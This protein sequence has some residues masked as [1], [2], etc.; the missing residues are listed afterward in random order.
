MI[1]A[2]PRLGSS[3]ALLLL[4]ASFCPA[5]AD[6][7]C[8][9][10]GGHQRLGLSRVVTIE[11]GGGY[12]VGL[13]TTLPHR[14]GLLQPNE[15]ALT[16]DDGPIPWITRS[17]LATLQQHCTKATFFSVGQ[18]AIA[19]PQVVREELDQGHSVG[20]HTWSHPLNLKRLKS[21]AATSEMERGFAGVSA[22]AGRPISA[23]FRFPGLSDS[24]SMVAYL[25]G[26]GVAAVSVDVVSN[27]SYI[28]DA[29]KLIRETL[30]KIEAN[31]GGII[32]FHD[33][34]ATTAKALPVILDTLAQRGYH[35]VQIVSKDALRPDP[36]LV[37]P[38]APKVEQAL[39]LAQS[40]KQPMVPFYGAV[41]PRPAGEVFA[42]TKDG[43]GPVRRKHAGANK[44]GLGRSR[45]QGWTTSI[46]G[47]WPAS[48]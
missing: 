33:I 19:Y 13:T 38:L 14:E 12:V 17:I 10:T 42:D 36:E 35:A 34:K 43:P 41:G 21:Q 45:P 7:G 31:H 15:V 5:L 16:F 29:N 44:D 18:M 37:A 40:A 24:A 23:L 30:A 6:E 26:R 28:H 1:T 22:A 27:D 25:E 39:A 20:T 48:D 4:A 11:P 8:S 3:L 32:L 9:T 47:P 46:N 2:L